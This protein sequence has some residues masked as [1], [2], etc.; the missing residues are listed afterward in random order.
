MTFITNVTEVPM[1][2]GTHQYHK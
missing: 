1:R 2:E